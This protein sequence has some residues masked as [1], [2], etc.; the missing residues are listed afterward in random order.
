MKNVELSDAAYAALQQLADAKGVTP[1]DIIAALLNVSRPPLAGDAL[2]FHLTSLEFTAI[3]D[4]T[5]RYLALLGWVAKTHA[6]DFADFVSHQDSGRRYLA[7]SRHEI[8]EIRQ[9]NHARQIPGTHYWAV[10][11]ID[12]ATQRRFVCRLL[13]F[14]GCHDETVALACRALG[15]AAPGATTHS[16][17]VA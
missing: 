6:V 12:A 8:Q 10:M 3:A 16:S 9:R 11:S 1:A 17:L 4:P 14:I 7:L 2:L 5:D 15:P 13:E